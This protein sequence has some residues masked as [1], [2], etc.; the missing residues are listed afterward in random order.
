M[1]EDDAI[2][3]E[4]R[5]LVS[6]VIGSK[7]MHIS[8]TIP[9][10]IKRYDTLLLATD[11]LIDNVEK[12]T[13]VDTIRKGSIEKNINGLC[14]MVTTRMSNPEEL[15]KPDDVTCILFRRNS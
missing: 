8:M 15:Y 4:D 7:E 9:V 1:H 2:Y 6:N 3:H 14:E 12:Q 10:H 13:I 5:H 11:G